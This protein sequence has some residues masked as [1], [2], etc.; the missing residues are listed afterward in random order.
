MF[1][2]PY[3]NDC[4]DP[5][6]G[7]ESREMTARGFRSIIGHTDAIQ[8]FQTAISNGRIGHAYL[9][10]GEAGS[11]KRMMADA[12]AETLLCS[13]PVTDDA[14]RPDACLICKSCLKAAD[15]NHPDIITVRHEKPGVISVSEIREQLVGTVD[16][17][18][19]ESRYKVYIIPDADK[20]NPQ[21]QNALLKTIEE[22][23]EYAV[24]LLLSASPEAL[25]PTIHSRCVT[26]NLKPVPDRELAAYLGDTLHIPDYEARV[27]TSFA[28]GN[29]GRAVRAYGDETFITRRDKTI[30]LVKRVHGMDTATIMEVIKYIKEDRDYMGDF[31]DFLTM[32]FRDVLYFKATAD[33]DQLIFTREISAIRAQAS[34]SSY[35][36][37]QEILNAI[38]RCAVR[39]RSNV[40]FE[41]ALELLLSSIKENCNA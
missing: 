17:L 16:I 13:Q 23:P 24:I 9:I 36:G 29:V 22:P 8:F 4:T 1:T 11:G 14:M 40:N 37:L 31:F 19:Y 5:G 25:L 2:V 30:D 20:M 27:L 7:R 18:P 39:L 10:T 6:S 21:A 3:V 15:G 34:S 12:F 33:V 28:Q 38:D 26:V 41:L 32:W 35:G